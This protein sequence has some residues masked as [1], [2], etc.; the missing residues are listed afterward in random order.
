MTSQEIMLDIAEEFGFDSFNMV[1]VCRGLGVGW[2]GVGVVTQNGATKH[3][4]G[5]HSELQN[6]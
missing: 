5:F 2:S 3:T 1:C 4:F 6:F